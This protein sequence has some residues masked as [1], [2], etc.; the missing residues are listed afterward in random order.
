MEPLSY[1][2]LPLPRW[3]ER[4][5]KPPTSSRTSCASAMIRRRCN[6]SGC[7]SAPLAFFAVAELRPRRS[8]LALPLETR[9]HLP[10]FA[11]APSVIT[12]FR[13]P[14]TLSNA[15]FIV[16]SQ[17]GR[18]PDL[19]AATEFARASAARTVAIVNAVPHLL[20]RAPPNLCPGA[21]PS[22]ARFRGD[23]DGDRL[24]GGRRR[25]RRR[26]G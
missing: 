17:S 10:V 7:W 13:K 11:S 8:V 14:L 25:T 19:V 22:K 3:R 20:S 9:L 16:I 26:I 23:Q 2:D 5:A 21:G 4:F 6:T 24:D 12:A 1:P 15:L 18:S